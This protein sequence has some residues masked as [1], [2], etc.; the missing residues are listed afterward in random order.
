[1]TSASPVALAWG[2]G[3]SAMQMEGSWNI[4]GKGPS[5][6]D[7][8]YLNHSAHPTHGTPFRAADHYVHYKEDLAFLGEYGAT[9]YR[10]SFS[11]PRILPDCTGNVNQKAID[12]YNNYIDEIIKNGAEPFATMFHWDLPQ[13]CQDKFNGLQNPTAFVDA[14]TE[15]SQVLLSAFGSKVTYWLT[16]NEP[17]ANCDFCMHRPQFAPFTTTTD[18]LYYKCMHASLL[19]HGNVV[20]KARAMPGGSK[21]KFGLPNIMEWH[22]PDPGYT[23]ATADESSSTLRQAEWYFDPCFFGDYGPGIKAVHPQIPSFTAAESNL[24]NGSCDFIAVNIYSSFTNGLP[25]LPI[26]ETEAYA[27]QE[28]DD[29]QYHYDM[30]YW[31]HPRPE[32]IR[33]LPQWLAKR[34]NKEVVITELGY[35]VPR[36]LE[37]S[38]TQAVNDD[39]R[40]QFWTLAGPQLLAAI[41]EDKTPLT[42]VLAW[43]LLDNYEFYTYEFRWGH[44]AV[45]YWD[46]NDKT[47]VN[48]DTG[49]LK[50]EAKGS[51][52]WMSKY[53]GANT[54]SPYSRQ[55]ATNTGGNNGS[56]GIATVIGTS[57]GAPSGKS[58]AGRVLIGGLMIALSAVLL[59]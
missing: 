5:V 17:R 1:M 2:F 52:K 36:S 48:L 12:Y 55:G 20:Q 13:A 10:F 30:P 51:L 54:V 32:G 44:V 4:D 29:Y 22:D 7:H 34:Y 58:D 19:A 41:N 35:H 57:T 53:F 43:S 9:A 8:A 6:F 56:H 16:L 18:D 3:G 14:F 21:W 24:M 45:D 38:F 50:R 27:L 23:D 25:S 42:A 26:G 40:T 49:S 31:P 15:Y 39:L 28:V 47:K 11:W 46:P 33:L 59:F 37:T